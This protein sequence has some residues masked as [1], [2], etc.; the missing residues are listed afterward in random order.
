MTE[1]QLFNGG[2]SS[3]LART[4]KATR[5]RIRGVSYLEH[6]RSN[7]ESVDAS[8]RLSADPSV[9]EVENSIREIEKAVR[10]LTRREERMS[11]RVHAFESDLIAELGLLADRVARLEMSVAAAE[12]LR[13]P[14]ERRL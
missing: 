13:E 14:T 12:R 7:D 8:P 10:Q 5:D 9:I 11:D 6:A 2:M 1:N 4:V 3:A